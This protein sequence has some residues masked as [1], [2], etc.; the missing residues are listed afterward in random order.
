MA[1]GSRTWAPLFFGFIFGGFLG[2]LLFRVRDTTNQIQIVPHIQTD[3]QVFEE[4]PVEVHKLPPAPNNVQNPSAKVVR[5]RFAATELGIRDKLIVIMLG[6][7]AL[8]VALNSSIGEH[9]PRIQIYVEATRIDN[10]MSVLENLQ[11]YRLNEVNGQRAHMHIL[12]SIFDL[13]LHESYD[14]FFFMPDTTY[15]NPFE[16]MRLVNGLK[17]NHPIAFGHA[18][19]GKILKA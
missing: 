5:A 9:I 10:D 14:W 4:W 7:S 6:Q 16:L 13:A 18:D 2:C 8:S 15:V 17:W 19:S 12:N 3:I 11:P 1:C